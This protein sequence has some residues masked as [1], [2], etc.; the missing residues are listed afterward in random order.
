MSAARIVRGICIS[1]RMPSCMRAPPE[2]GTTISAASRSTARRAAATNASPTAIP[3]EP[4]MNAK[5]KAATTAA[6]PPI[7]PS[8]T[9]SASL[10]LAAGAERGLVFAQPLGVALAVAEAQRVGRDLR[11]LDRLEV[12]AVEQQLE[13][14]LAADAEMVAAAA[15]DLADL[16]PA[17]GGTASARRTGTCARDCPARPCA[18]TPGSSAGRN[19]SASSCA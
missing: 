6:T 5:S 9:A 16:P 7:R 10:A 4:P 2:A 13:P 1:D 8:A 18:G 12:A 3:I 11:R 15:A 19:W 17:R 14:R